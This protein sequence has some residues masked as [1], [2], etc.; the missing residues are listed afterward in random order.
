MSTE[1]QNLSST[2]SPELSRWELRRQRKIKKILAITARTLREKGYR[3]SSLDE[4]ADELDLTKASLYHYFDSKEA[5]VFACL[6][7]CAQRVSSRLMAIERGPGPHGERLEALIRE[8]LRIL[9]YDYHELVPLF[10]YPGDWPP[11]LADAV[12]RWRLEHD[13]PFR[14]V[15]AAG[16]AEGEFEVI[17]PRA[18]RLCLHGALN[19]TLTWV[20]PGDG[21]VEALT[22]QIVAT[23]LR[24]F[25]GTASSDPA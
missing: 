10:V 4:I 11:Q 1:A 2:D 24:M 17:N 18:A 25:I 12:N 3:G 6:E 13:A 21:D 20:H 14:R 5:L 19:N 7:D 23:V 22:D 16:I 9:L 15:I 8:Q